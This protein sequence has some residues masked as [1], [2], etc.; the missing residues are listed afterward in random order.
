MKIN[1]NFLGEGAGEGAKQKPSMGG[2]WIF[3]GAALLTLLFFTCKSY[4]SHIMLT[5]G[6]LHMTNM[7]FAPK[8]GQPQSHFDSKTR[9]PNMQL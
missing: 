7:R 5:N 8:Q 3:S 2:V 6:H 9:T 4:C 1:W